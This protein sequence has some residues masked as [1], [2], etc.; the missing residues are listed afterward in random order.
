MSMWIAAS[1]VLAALLALFFVKPLFEPAL[2]VEAD[3]RSGDSF[4]RL[5][6][7]KER[8]LRSLKDLELD[9][10]MGKV[11]DAEFTSAR[12]ALALEAGRLIEE[13]KRHGGR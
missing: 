13:I 7:Q 10:A 3:L 8:V 9:H 5:V 6:D 11:G 1:A 2:A 4:L 12:Q